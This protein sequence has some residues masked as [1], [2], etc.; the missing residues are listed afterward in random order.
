MSPSVARGSSTALA[1]AGDAETAEPDPALLT[2]LLFTTIAWQQFRMELDDGDVEPPVWDVAQVRSQGGA[3]LAS[4]VPDDDPIR[5]MAA[6]ASPDRALDAAEALTDD[7]IV[8]LCDYRAAVRRSR[9]RFEPTPSQFAPRGPAIP[10]CPRT[11]ETRG[12]G[13]RLLLAIPRPHVQPLS[14]GAEHAGAKGAPPTVFVHGHTHLPDRSQ[15]G[16]NMI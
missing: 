15:T 3:F 13:I 4:A 6:K 1:A 9:R 8:A 16:A 10:E 14:G 2:Y 7:E 12:G 5:P 11:P